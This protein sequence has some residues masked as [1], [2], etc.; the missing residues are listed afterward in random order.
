M[1]IHFILRGLCRPCTPAGTFF[2][3]RKY[4]KNTRPAPP[5]TSNLMLHLS[6]NNS[7]RSNKFRPA[8]VSQTFDCSLRQRSDIFL[9]S[10][11]HFIFYYFVYFILIN[12]FFQI[13]VRNI[14]INLYKI[15]QHI[16]INVWNS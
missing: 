12:C 13:C 8:I 5:F 2:L 7:L 4:P 1:G 16:I 10:F 15:F 11:R 9:T 14:I 3:E 6:R